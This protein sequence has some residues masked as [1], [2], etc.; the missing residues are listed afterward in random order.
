MQTTSQATQQ[1]QPP[2]MIG[3]TISLGHAPN[4]DVDDGYWAE[5]EEPGTV[6]HDSVTS[7]GQ[8]QQAVRLY[9]SRN[10]LGG[11]NWAG[12]DL[13]LDGKLIGRISYN[14]RAWRLGGVEMEPT[15]PVLGIYADGAL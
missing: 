11:G 13:R 14:G 9:I 2:R 7:L 6:R 5:P 15:D 12:G 1:S 10:N 3:L 4:P 8:A